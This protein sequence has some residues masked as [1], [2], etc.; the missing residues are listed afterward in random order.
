MTSWLHV[1]PV[2]GRKR[3]SEKGGYSKWIA[4]RQHE[5]DTDSPGAARGC[6]GVSRRR[7]PP[8][9]RGVL[10]AQCPFTV[11]CVHIISCCFAAVERSWTLVLQYRTIKSHYYDTRR[12]WACR[13]GHVMLTCADDWL[14]EC[15]DNASVPGAA[16][17]V[18]MTSPGGHHR[19]AQP[20]QLACRKGQ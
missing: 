10:A 4:R 8:G 20:Q 13:G 7:L 1:I 3:R 17:H 6:G 5:F 12:M 9:H 16:L 2:M 19:S 18:I 14:E 11:S 15:L